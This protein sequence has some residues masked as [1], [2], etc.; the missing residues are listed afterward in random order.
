MNYTGW[1]TE[2]YQALDQ[3]QIAKKDYK[4]VTRLAEDIRRKV[5]E[6]NS[7]GHILVGETNWEIILKII[8]D[9]EQIR[10]KYRYLCTESS[11]S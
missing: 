6:L 3:K 4:I 11:P 10:L 8:L 5:L 2:T 1:T 7:E 9:R